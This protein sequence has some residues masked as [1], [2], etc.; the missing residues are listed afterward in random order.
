MEQ[1]EHENQDDE[2][3]LIDL[4]AVLWHRKKMIIAVTAAAAVGALVFAV[5]SLLLPPEKSPLPNKYSPQALMLINDSSSSGGAISSMLSSSGLGS[6]AGLAGISV[7]GGAT[8]SALAVYLVGTNSF[9][10]AVV[11]KFDLIVRYEIREYLRAESR[12]MLKKKLT[13]SFDDESGVFD[14]TFEDRDP[15]FARSVVNFCVEQLSL[16]FDELGV[17]KNKLEK[18]N[19]EKNIKYAYEEIERLE[20]EGHQLERSIQGVAA[21][22]IPSITLGRS[23]IT[24]ELAAQQRVYSELKVQYELLKVTMASEKPVFQILE[25]AEVPDQKSGPSRGLLCVIV[26]FAG[27]F[28]AVFLA[29]ILNALANIRQDPEAMAKLRPKQKNTR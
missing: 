24:L 13:A 6:L 23:R 29:F 25:M 15:V 21:G 11:D 3:S 22:N 7:G 28:L 16:W 17:D 2:I 26:V 18:E 20:Q 27:G 5:L 12:K 10:D 9:L 1:V 4:F 8:Y 19:L 14:I